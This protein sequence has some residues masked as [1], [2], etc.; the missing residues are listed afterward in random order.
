VNEPVTAPI[1]RVGHRKPERR[2]R[3]R[4]PVRLR[5]Y[6]RPVALFAAFLVVTMGVFG[7]ARVIPYITGDDLYEPP[8]VTQ[9]IAGTVSLFDTSTSHTVQLTFAQADYERVLQAWYDDGEKEY[10]E[11]DL[12][13]DGT[14]VENVGVRLKGNSTLMALRDPDD[15]DGGQRSPGGMQPP[16]GELPEGVAPAGGGEQGDEGGPQQMGGLSSVALSEAEPENLPWLISFDEFAEGRRYQGHSEIAVRPASASSTFSANEA[17]ALSLV[18]DTGQTSQGHVYSTFTVNDRPTTTRLLVEHPDEAYAET[19]FGSDAVLYKSLSTG[20]FTDK[21]DDPTEYETDFQQINRIGSQDLQPVI[22]LIQWVNS[23]TDEEFTT[24][25]GEHLDIDSFARYLATQNL[26]LNFDDMSG[27]GRNYYLR[28]DLETEKFEVITWDL[29]FAFGGSADA[30]P[31]DELRM[32]GLGGPGA[33][34]TQPNATQPQA[35]QPEA[36][37]GEGAAEAG[38]DQQGQRGPMTGNKLKERFL[39]TPAFKEAYEQAYRVL[40]QQI[41]ADSGAMRVLDELA[42]TVPTSDTLDAATITAD[43]DALRQTVTTRTDAL[44]TDPVI[45]GAAP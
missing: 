6:W 13:I 9:D 4:I 23:A 17:L 41:Y 22:D 15:P 39:A 44:A 7:T 24:E 34:A 21:G 38:G 33:A 1:R 42:A 26:L 10:L 37:E 8:A 16:E 32:G 28:Y 40:Y 45:T 25:L 31:H 5:H 3:H 18:A 12:V 36:A 11:A 2:W 29:N 35:A 14:R 20:S 27:P 30:G 19:E 43:L